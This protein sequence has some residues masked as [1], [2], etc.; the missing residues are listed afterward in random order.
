MMLGRGAA[1]RLT[2]YLNEGSRWQ[3]KPLYEAILELLLAKGLAGG[4]VVRALAGFTRAQGIVTAAILDLSV[5][6]PL[7]IEVVDTADALDRVLPDLYLMLEKGLITVDDVEVVKYT[8]APRGAPAAAAPPEETRK[9]TMKAKQ[10]SVHISEKDLH[11]GEPLHEAILKRFSMEEF[12]GATVYRALEGFG[13]HHQIHRRRLLGLGREAPIVV[14]MV[15]TEK[16]VRK[17]MAILDGMLTHGAVI[18]TDVEATFYGQSAEG[19][20]GEAGGAQG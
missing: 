2:I 12:A 8:G 14:L 18:V 1:K 11:N 4:T 17:A 10:L 20:A 9:V 6:L 13:A 15:D 3:G 5:S 7:R 19:K 16:N